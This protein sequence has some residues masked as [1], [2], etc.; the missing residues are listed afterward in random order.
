M[1][2]LSGSVNVNGGYPSQY[3]I[4]SSFNYRKNKFSVF[5][6]INTSLRETKGGVYTDSDFFLPDTTYTSLTNRDRTSNSLS[7]GTRAGFSFYPNK[8]NIFNLP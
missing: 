6:S 3:G 4:S 7:F 5:G 2:G 8:N 1:K